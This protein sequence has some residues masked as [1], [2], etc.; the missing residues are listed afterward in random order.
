MADAVRAQ[1]FYERVVGLREVGR[2]DDAA[3][4]LGAG[5]HPLIELAPRPGAPPRPAGTAGLFHLA[6]LVPSRLEL[7]RSLRRLGEAGWPLAG[8]SDHL[9]SEALYLSDPEGNGIELYSDRP[10][11]DWPRANGGI[12]MATLPLDLQA[13]AAELSGDVNE[14]SAIA[15]DT[16]LG[17]VHLQVGDLAAAERFYRE[18]LGFEVTT[19]AYPGALFLAA[20]GYHHHV[21][22]NTW[23]GEGAPPAPAG[24]CGRVRF[25]VVV[26]NGE[27]LQAVTKR[28]D[29]A[30]VEH[31]SEDGSLR[32]HDPDGNGVLVR[33]PA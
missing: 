22:L 1:D 24:T 23:A 12:R 19:R 3:V 25:E 11:A 31:Q 33:L 13:L 5:G 32:T 2:G 14:A 28:I 4:A 21:G 16:R 17:H 30:G 6:L 26:A 10:P 27:E 8:A 9:V 15:S 7:A 29:A 18:G 20:G